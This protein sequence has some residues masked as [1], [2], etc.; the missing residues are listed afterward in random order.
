MAQNPSTFIIFAGAMMGFTLA[1]LS[2]LNVAGNAKSSFAK[3]SSPGEWYE[4]KTG[5][6]RIGITLHLGAILPAGFLMVW[7]FIPVIR[8]KV[9]IFH[10]INGYVIILLVFISNVGALMICRRAFGGTIETQAGVGMLVILTTVSVC[11][12]Y[13]NIKR[14]QIDQH[15][16][17]MLRAMFYLGSII[18]LRLIMIISAL[19]TSQFDSYYTTMSCDKISSI[20]AS[21]A[22]SVEDLYPQC[23]DPSSTTDGLVIVHATFASGQPEQI[24]ASLG[25]SFGMALWLAIFLHLVLVEIYLGLTPKES[26]RLREV[27]HQRQL[28]Q[29]FKSPGSA[30]LTSHR[31]GEASS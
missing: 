26:N 22:S 17:W 9:L 13:Y 15:R 24:A 8:Q 11:L 5:F 12:A 2:Y 31:W 16:A 14:L 10:R 7:Q 3:S 1:R 25:A 4:Y 23:S 29:G 27:S 21:N 30:G 18:T 6:R 19:L 28:E 20:Y